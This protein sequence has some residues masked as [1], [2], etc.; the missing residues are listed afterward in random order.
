MTL[1]SDDEEDFY[2]L[3]GLRRGRRRDLAGLSS[4]KLGL[5]TNRSPVS[6]IY[7]AITC[8]Q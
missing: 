8:V 2:I 6:T 5:S 7:N 4:N 1:A 3:Y